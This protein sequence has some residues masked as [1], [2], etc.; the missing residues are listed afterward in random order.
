M[1]RLADVLG[2]LCLATDLGTGKPLDHGLRT[3]LLA[4]DI[5][6]DLRLDE[7]TLVDLYYLA[8]L[9]M[10][11]CTVDASRGAEIM[12][13]EVAVGGAMETLDLE[14]HLQMVAWM[15]TRFARQE[16]PLRRARLLTRMLRFS[17]AR[18]GMLA[19]HCEVA[20]MLAQRLGFGEQVHHGL[21]YVYERW[22]GRGQP[23]GARGEQVPLSMRIQPLARDVEIFLRAGGVAAARSVV[24]ERSGGSYDPQLAERVGRRLPALAQRLEVP[25]VWEAVLEAEPGASSGAR[26]CR[27]G[28][29]LEGRR[30][31]RRR[32]VAVYPRP[33]R[34]RG[35]ART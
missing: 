11:G 27:T 8:M 20:Q 13:D 29:R 5:G 17:T 32:E 33:L 14:D 18:S 23:S 10:L 9:R 35:G 25:S 6:H 34:W 26:R 24:H 16:P 4:M 1:T 19:G 30:R 22:D 2:V 21:G 31:F 7:S 12:G 3:C 15:L 28:E